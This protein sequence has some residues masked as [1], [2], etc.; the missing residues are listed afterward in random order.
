MHI[1]DLGDILIH[2]RE[3]GD[4]AGRPVVFANALGTDLRLW[5]GIMPL[6]PESLRLLR[7]DMRGHG[8]SGVLVAAPPLGGFL[9]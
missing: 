8:L 6:L 9:L 5:D 3:D 7:Y 2:W 1:L 4:P